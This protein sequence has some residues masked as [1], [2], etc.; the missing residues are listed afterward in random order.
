MQESEVIHC[1]L[2]L[3][4]PT[5]EINS[6]TVL[7]G[8]L[9]RIAINLFN[10]WAGCNLPEIITLQIR[11][12]GEQNCCIKANGLKILAFSY[13][14]DSW[15]RFLQ[16]YLNQLVE[17]VVARRIFE[18]DED[19][20]W[21]EP[22]ASGKV[23]ILYLWRSSSHDWQCHLCELDHP[24][25]IDVFYA[26]KNTGEQRAYL[27]ALFEKFT[28]WL[29]KDFFG[30]GAVP[31]AR[32]KL[33]TIKVNPG[34][35]WFLRF[36]VS[37]FCQLQYRGFEGYADVEWIVTN[38]GF[39]QNCRER[40]QLRAEL[41]DMQTLLAHSVVVVNTYDS[42]KNIELCSQGTELI[43]KLFSYLQDIEFQD[44]KISLR[45]F[46]NPPAQEINQLLQSTCNSYFFADFEASEGYW[47]TGEGM[48]LSWKSLDDLQRSV[49]ANCATKVA[50][51]LESRQRNLS[52]I[53]LMRVFHCNSIFDP[54]MVFQDGREP[55]DHHSIVR[56]FLNAGVQRVEGGLTM[57]NYLDY[58]C[59]LID[60]FCRPE[61]LKFILKL[62]SW[63]RGGDFNDLSTQI[64]SFLSGCHREP[65]AA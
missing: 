27:D 36:P 44:K 54:H 64:N 12:H 26:L 20:L 9:Y 35:L 55:A 3:S 16:S 7:D 8:G 57:E 51:P 43:I 50:L 13:Q 30:A 22:G 5:V 24:G 61:P 1:N 32:R 40:T 39:I 19:I 37:V 10:A 18:E 63:E 31:A 11:L 14:P 47:E 25:D 60:I 4:A 23:W 52:H 59:S 56:G 45:W 38:K 53:R 21:I 49:T 42:H 29:P 17:L 65:I 41:S 48:S 33:L 2:D 28:G 6:P 62:K 15:N 34:Q 58:L 46:L